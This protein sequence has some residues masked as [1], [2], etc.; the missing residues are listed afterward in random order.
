[1][2]SADIGGAIVGGVVGAAGS[3]YYTGQVNWNNVAFGAAAGA[4]SNSLGIAGKIGGW[5]SKFF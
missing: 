2:F 5:F 1:M 3:Y 4:I